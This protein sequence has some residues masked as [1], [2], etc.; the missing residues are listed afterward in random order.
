[1]LAYS[2]LSHS[3]TLSPSTEDPVTTE[4]T[5]DEKLDADAGDP[6]RTGHGTGRLFGRDR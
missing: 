3:L 5:L 1:M 4:A 6:A 2:P